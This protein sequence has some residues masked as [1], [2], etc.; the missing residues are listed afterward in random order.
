MIAPAL[1]TG[2][3]VDRLMR[4]P[5]QTAI[6]LGHGHIKV[7]SY[8]VTVTPPGGPRMPN[9][10]ECEMR[11]DAGEE[12]WL[13]DGALVKDGLEVKPGPVWDPIPRVRTLL[14]IDPYQKIHPDRLVGKGV[15][16]TPQGDDVLVGYIAGCALFRH[17]WTDL[18][19]LLSANTTTSLSSTLLFHAC[20]GELPQPAHALLE[21]GDPEPLLDF[22]H[23]S[24]KGILLGLALACPY[25]DHTLPPSRLLTLRRVMDLPNS[26]VRA[27]P[28]VPGDMGQ[29]LLLAG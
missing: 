20:L 4:G 19:T 22:G 27:Y 29:P 16:L 3:Y 24:G 12:A 17:Q 9:G 23:S 6:G 18:E 2:W 1:S 21:A 10:I 8:V 7:A 15:G 13:G 25:Q 14:D 5:R 28:Y 11:I 26:V